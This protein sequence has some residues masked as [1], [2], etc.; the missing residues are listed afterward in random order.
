MHHVSY[1]SYGEKKSDKLLCRRSTA[2]PSCSQGFFSLTT[3]SDSVSA[4]LPSS[5]GGGLPPLPYGP[6][7]SASRAHTASYVAFSA[8]KSQPPMALGE[9]RGGCPFAVNL[10]DRKCRRKDIY[11]NNVSVEKKE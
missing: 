1:G 3:W 10:Y 11:R 8:A 9:E 2:S 5:F 4:G 6:A 7:S